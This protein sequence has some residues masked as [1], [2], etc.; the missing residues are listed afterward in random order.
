MI[1]NMVI[2]TENGTDTH[3]LFQS[4][5]DSFGTVDVP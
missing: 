5:K 1:W 2:Y 3:L 4:I